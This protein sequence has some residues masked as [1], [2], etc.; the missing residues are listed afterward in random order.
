MGGPLMK[1]MKYSEILKANR[2]LAGGLC[3]ESFQIALLGNITV[4][5]LKEILEYSL[6]SSG[7]NAEVS[8]GN[9]DNIVQ[10]SAAFKGSR[11]LIIFWEAANFIDGGQYKINLMSPQELEAL[12]SK[13]KDEFDLLVSHT[14]ETSLILLNKFSS[15]IFTHTNIGATAHDGL[16][17]RLN[18]YL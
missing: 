13:I 16:C 11:L 17:Q 8:L 14:R 9:Y 15:L 4:A 18:A 10:D 2:D 7:I 1:N 5:Q 12:E 3:G 6:R